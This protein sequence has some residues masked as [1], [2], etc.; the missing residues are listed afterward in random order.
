MYDCLMDQETQNLVCTPEEFEHQ[1]VKA[2]LL[3]ATL[4]RVYCPYFKE[5][6]SFNRKGL[7]HIKF[8]NWNKSRPIKDQYMR[9]KL[10]HLVPDVIKASGTLQGIRE[11]YEFERQKKYGKW[12]A[13]QR[14]VI[15][16][17]FLAVIGRNRIKVIIKNVEGGE[18]YFWSIIPYWGM[19]EF[20]KRILHTGNPMED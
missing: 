20:R 2:E 14:R 4:D 18:S 17:E 5:K 1:K 3:Y 7:D 13:P 9:F 15:F 10:L 6:I 11:T 16:Y 19:D 12:E 8:K